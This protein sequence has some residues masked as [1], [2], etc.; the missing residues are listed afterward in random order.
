MKKRT[1]LISAI[2]A[3]IPLGQ[4]LI[5]KPD[6]FLLSTGLMLYA[7]QKLKAESSDFYFRRG[8]KKYEAKDYDG[9]IYELTKAIKRNSWEVYYLYRGNCK[10]FARDFYGAISDTTKAI[11]KGGQLMPQAYGSRG[12]A[13]LALGDKQGACSDWRKAYALGD[14]KIAKFVINRC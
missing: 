10:Y 11:D 5:I 2:L 6:F 1:I 4:P 3:L 7:P 8:V 13:K 14:E 9:C 12:M